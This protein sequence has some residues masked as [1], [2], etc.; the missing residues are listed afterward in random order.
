MK[1]AEKIFSSAYESTQ[2]LAVDLSD[3]LLKLT[4][5]RPPVNVLNITLLNALAAVLGQAAADARVRVLL[6]T[7][8]GERYF[9]AGVEVAEHGAAQV[10]EMLAAFHDVA[11]RLRAFPLPTLAAL[12]GSALGGGL[13]LALA[14]DM[15]LAVA[16][17][18]LGQPEIRLGVFAPVAA[19]LL[20][21]LLP[22][23]LAHEMLLGGRLLESSDA[24][25][26]GL[27]NRV[28]PR[29]AFDAGVAEFLAPC[30][31]LSRAAQ[32]H[33]KRALRAAQG[34]PFDAALSLLE[35]QYLDELM[36]T[37]DA[38][39]GIAAFLEKRVPQWRNR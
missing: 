17:A 26:F 21:R 34:Q 30:L 33:N 14:C 20:P 2:W 15:R 4:L 39:E 24:L 25:R 9:S 5:D 19:I 31:Q 8:R 3:G 10:E 28:W 22:P 37:H 13:E 18:Q 27:L 29:E 16:D 1:E 32:L 35:R 36:A 12:N 6:L 38:H 11:R 7:A 23:G